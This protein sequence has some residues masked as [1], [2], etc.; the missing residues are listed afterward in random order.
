[1]GGDLSFP[2]LV[3]NQLQQGEKKLGHLE[4]EEYIEQN[5]NDMTQEKKSLHNTGKVGG[6]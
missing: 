3:Q 2:C 4:G 1:M 6:L 5:K